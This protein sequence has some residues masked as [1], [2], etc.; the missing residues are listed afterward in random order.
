MLYDHISRVY[1]QLSSKYTKGLHWIICGDTNDLKLDP[2]L[3]MN[4]NFTQVVQDPTRLNPPRILDPI[5]T[6]LTGFYQVPQ[7]LPPLDVDPFKNGKP[8]DHKMVGMEP[9]SLISNKPARTKRAIV[10]RP[11]RKN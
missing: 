11:M 6:T 5:I 4:S 7:C 2:I 10:Y 1:S 3:H 8:S 9:I